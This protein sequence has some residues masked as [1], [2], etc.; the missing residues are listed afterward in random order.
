MKDTIICALVLVIVFFAGFLIYRDRLSRDNSGMDK[1]PE[2][3]YLNGQWDCAI[4]SYGEEIKFPGPLRYE[5]LA[6]LQLPELDYSCRAVYLVINELN[7]EEYLSS[8]QVS[9]LVE[10]AE[11]HKNFNFIYLGSHALREFGN[12]FPDCGFD[13]NDLSF[14]YVTED[15]ERLTFTG[16]F[17][18]DYIPYVKKNDMLIGDNVIHFIAD[19]LKKNK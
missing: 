4:Y 3:E 6:T 2:T 15:G 16:V 17:I 9:E 19:N 8:D 13:D 1:S 12:L 18:K 14:A 5:K 7:A 11:K 10:T